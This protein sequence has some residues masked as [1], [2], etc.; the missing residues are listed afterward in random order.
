MVDPKERQASKRQVV[1]SKAF[2]NAIALLG[3]TG[4]EAGRFVGLSEAGISRLRRG[5]LLLDEGSKAFELAALIVRSFRSL[6]AITGGDEAAIRAW[7][8]SPNAALG[9]APVERMLS[10][11]GLV[12]VVS[13]LDARRAPL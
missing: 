5:D 4:R 1:L 2:V 7:I 12:D 11:G 9:G 10:V 8:R 3:L 6:D 13:Y